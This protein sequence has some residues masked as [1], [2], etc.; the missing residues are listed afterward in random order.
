M[1]EQLQ[2]QLCGIITLKSILCNCAFN[3]D[4]DL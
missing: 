4:V 1:G 3:S 2:M